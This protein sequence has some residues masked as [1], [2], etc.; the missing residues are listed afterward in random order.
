[1]L[2]V[3]VALVSEE[4]NEHRKKLIHTALFNISAPYFAGPDL[5]LQP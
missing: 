4:A 3:D 5:K 1:M 2:T